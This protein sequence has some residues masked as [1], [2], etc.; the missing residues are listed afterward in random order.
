MKNKNKWLRDDLQQLEPYISVDEEFVLKLNANES[1]FSL[2]NIIKENFCD[3]IMHDENLHYYPDSNCTKLRQ[4]LSEINNV[5]FDNIICGVGS[6]QLID[7]LVKALINPNEYVLVPNPSFSMYQITTNINHGNIAYYDL[8]EN[9]QYNKDSILEK[10]IDINPKIIFICNPNNP[11][12]TII[13]KD[14]IIHI[15]ENTESLVVVDEA[16]VEFSENSMVQDTK[17]Y[18]NLLVLRTFSK[19]YQ[20]AGLRMGYGIADIEIIDALNIVK[21][22]YN[23]PTMSQFMA[24]QILENRKI[25]EKNINYLVE[26]RNDFFEKLSKLDF[27]EVYESHA[28]YVFVKSTKELFLPLKKKKML[29]RKITLDDKYY[30]G[31][32]FVEYLRISIGTKEDMELLY[33]TIIKL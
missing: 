27:I 9:F 8:G 30:E 25:V 21:P 4:K 31:H 16:Y 2:P 20:T 12:G 28:N 15:L 3:F 24:I 32:D 7:I 19:A 22:P 11:T 6:D 14:D 29:I 26:V 10:A 5:D 33:N 23:I 13:N 18:K 17:K 1:P